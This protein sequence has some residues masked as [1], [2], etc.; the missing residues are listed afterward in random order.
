M[1]HQV[2]PLGRLE[3]RWRVHQVGLP[4]RGAGHRHRVVHG[5][6]R[7]LGGQAAAHVQAGGVTDVVAVGLERHAQHG[8][9]LAGQGA[10][11]GLPGQR[12]HPVPPSGVDGVH[13]AEQADDRADPE[14]GRGGAERAD[15]L[16][17]AAAAEAQAGRQ[18]AP[19]DPRVISEGL[20]ERDHVGARLLADLGHGVDER[21]LGRQERVRRHLDQFGRLQVHHQQRDARRQRPGVDRAE[22]FLGP[23][24]RDAR[25]DAVR[26]EA[27]LDREALPQEL[28]VPGQVDPLPGRGDG[29]DPVDQLPGGADRDGRLAGD[30][31]LRGQVR[32]QRVSRRVDVAQVRLAC[33]A[34]GCPH[35]QEMDLAE[36][37]YLGERRGEAE[38]AGIE[39]LAQQG[40]QA[41]FE[42]RSLAARGPCELLLVDVD[43]QHVMPEIRQ[44]DGVREP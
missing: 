30:Q 1:Q 33:L 43:G 17:Q 32:G 25:H 9:P 8:D 35:A 39:V 41:G 22:Q 7:P 40:F 24:G 34:L 10:A 19:A 12:G 14:G 11:R 2:G 6:D 27:V 29:P 28:R 26:D 37:S 36:R 20:G 15:V 38:P 4:F 44:A 18:E 31:A 23:A 5:H 21:D 42:E 3:D 16:G 13:R